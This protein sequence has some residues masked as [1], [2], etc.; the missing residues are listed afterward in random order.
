MEVEAVDEGVISKLLVAEGAQGVK[1][2][3]VIAELAGEGEAAAKGNGGAKAEAQKAPATVTASPA[4]AGA[5]PVSLCSLMR[6]STCARAHAG[7]P[8]CAGE[9]GRAS[10]SGEP[11]FSLPN[12]PFPLDRRPRFRHVFEA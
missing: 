5:Q 6:R 2:N 11:P 7:A 1:V 3:A 4:K 10:N 9:A 8:A 12:H